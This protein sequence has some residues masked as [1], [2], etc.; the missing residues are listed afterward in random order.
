MRLL[1]LL[2]ENGA[3]FARVAAQS[4]IAQID[5]NVY[6]Q[7]ECPHIVMIKGEWI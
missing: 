5:R 6:G 3:L 4:L 2:R 1:R 7:E